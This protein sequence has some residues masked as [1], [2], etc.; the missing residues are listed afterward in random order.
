MLCSMLVFCVRYCLCRV[1]L[2]LDMNTLRIFFFFFLL[3]SFAFAFAFGVSKLYS[4]Y[5]VHIIIYL[6][7]QQFMISFY[8]AYDSISSTVNLSTQHS[9]IEI[10]EFKEKSNLFPESF[11]VL[12]IHRKLI[13]NPISTIPISLNKHSN[14]IVLSMRTRISHPNKHK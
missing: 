9:F 3:S 13:I 11:Q 2:F 1:C 10:V 8:I 12:R 4:K 14:C 5:G 6:L 7:V